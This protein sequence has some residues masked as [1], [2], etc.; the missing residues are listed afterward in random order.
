MAKAR[1]FSYVRSL[2]DSIAKV[3]FGDNDTVDEIVGACIL[4]I[5]NN[6]SEVGDF[7]FNIYIYWFDICNEE[8]LD[9]LFLWW[10]NIDCFRDLFSMVK[11][12]MHRYYI[13]RIHKIWLMQEVTYLPDFSK[14]CETWKKYRPTSI[15]HIT[16]IFLMN[17]VF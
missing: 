5:S 2:L 10:L 13:Q 9:Q 7:I 17:M 16:I 6:P 3:G 14:F 15:W 12:T 11:N 1:R 4:V 8:L